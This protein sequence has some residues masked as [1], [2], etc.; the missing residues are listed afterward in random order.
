MT[1]ASLSAILA[2]RDVY[3][4]LAPTLACLRVQTAARRLE[5]ILVAPQPL[6]PPAQDLAAFH[7]LRVVVVPGPIVSRE[8]AHA[9]GVRVARAAAI[10]FVEDHVFPEVGWA[11]ALIAAFRASWALVTPTFESAN[12]SR[13]G[14]AAFF[15]SYGHW[16]APMRR[17]PAPLRASSNVAYRREVLLAYGDRLEA[18]LTTQE[19]LHRDLR[20]AGRELLVE[21]AAVLYHLDSSRLGPWVA[22]RF[23]GGLLF[24]AGRVQAH[25]WSPVRRLAYAA[26]LP[27]IPLVNLGRLVAQ[28]RRAGWRGWRLVWLLPALILGALIQALGEALGYL[29]GAG[30][31]AA[32]HNDKEFDRR[33]FVTPGDLRAADQLV[34][35]LVAAGLAGADPAA[36]PLSRYSLQ[37]DATSTHAES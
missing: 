22:E 6:S 7:S 36:P 11:A 34:A 33:R 29:F 31:A 8:A 15:F 37:L 20:L 32:R 3:A 35:E 21:P 24:A 14:L 1:E 9:A 2:T 28:A 13:L 16:A 19:H 17:G 30:R 12:R 25:R 23:D 5:V 4:T 27:L 18:M 26:A 10:V